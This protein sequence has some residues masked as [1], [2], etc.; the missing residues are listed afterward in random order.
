MCGRTSLF[1]PQSDLEDRFDA[2]AVQ[3]IRPRY[4]IAPG[5]DLAVIPNST[6]DEID[7]FEWG[8]V[9]SWVDDLDDWRPLIN[10]R[11]ETAAEKNSFRHAFKEQR[12]LVLADGFYE[13]QG[14]KGSK[15]PYRIE[16]EDGEPV[17]FA[18]LWETWGGNGEELRTVTILTTEPNNIVEKIHD[19]MPVMLEP[20]EESD[21]LNEND[22]K[23]LQQ[24]L[25]PY[26][27]GLT[28]A[29]EI[30]TA[31]NDPI[32][33]TEDILEPIGHDQSGLGQFS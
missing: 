8:L 11:S 14:K 26:P 12:C 32:N 13:W 9:P 4:N 24:M 27:E 2:E 6:P 18:G 25:D 1:V 29:Y 5:D 17:A 23:E 7:Q 31:V 16:R 3:D 10:A 28:R 21:W 15:R 33:D 30:S 20:E 22:L 19:R